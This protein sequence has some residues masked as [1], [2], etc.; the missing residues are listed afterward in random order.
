MPLRVLCCTA[1]TLDDSCPQSP[2]TTS[3]PPSNNAQFPSSA[4]PLP[5]RP[6]PH[7]L[8]PE[9]STPGT[10]RG[11]CGWWGCLLLGALLFATLRPPHPHSARKRRRHAEEREEELSRSTEQPLDIIGVRVRAVRCIAAVTVR[12]FWCVIAVF[13]CLSFRNFVQRGPRKLF[14]YCTLRRIIWG[15]PYHDYLFL[16][17]LTHP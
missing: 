1:V 6:A 10:I 9:G 14:S 12:G 5:P 17:L 2:T 7:P 3:A 15:R 13:G 8:P 11:S 16:A 4:R